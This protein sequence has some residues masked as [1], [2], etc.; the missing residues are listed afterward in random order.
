MFGALSN[1]WGYNFYTGTQN[2]NQKD[3]KAGLLI[4]T[5]ELEIWPPKVFPYLYRE[6]RRAF[7][8][9]YTSI[10]NLPMFVQGS[11]TC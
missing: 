4:H 7:V 1:T 8:M 9:I 3:D 6:V 11:H 10:D 5:F 2:M